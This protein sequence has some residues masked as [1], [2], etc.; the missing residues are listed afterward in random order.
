MKNSTSFQDL[1]LKDANLK[2]IWF[3]DVYKSQNPKTIFNIFLNTDIEQS[4]E[5]LD[6]MNEICTK[7]IVDFEINDRAILQINEVVDVSLPK[8]LRS[9]LEVQ[10]KGT[11]KLL[12]TDGVNEIIGIT[13]AP[14]D[15][16][17]NPASN[18]GSKILLKPPIIVKYGVMFLSN[19]N[20]QYYGGKSPIL[21]QKRKEIYR[22]VSVVRKITKNSISN[23]LQNEEDVEMQQR[24]SISAVANIKN[25][26]T[27]KTNIASSSSSPSASLSPSPTNN[28]QMKYNRQNEKVGQLTI[29]E[30]SPP[31][32]C[33][34]PKM[35]N[36][37]QFLSSDDSD[38]D[39]SDSYQE[40]P[41][42][43]SK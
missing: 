2:K 20:I 28:D 13:K 9:R 8:Y 27:T 30:Q 4:S 43:L 31:K 33:K 6:F 5:P 29:I 1:K 42:S 26:Q 37:A 17:I 7:G 40:A 38:F 35:S 41:N 3:D 21:I 19:D 10:R 39:S 16:Q 36:S 34:P 14:I 12:L 22:K 15:C 24:A 25:S 11:L 23:P 32:Y 18:P